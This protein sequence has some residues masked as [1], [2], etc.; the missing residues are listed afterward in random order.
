MQQKYLAELHQTCHKNGM[1]VMYCLCAYCFWHALVI[2]EK[3]WKQIYYTQVTGFW[4][5]FTTDILMVREDLNLLKFASCVMA[6]KCTA[7]LKSSFF[8]VF[9]KQNTADLRCLMFSSYV[10]QEKV[11]CHK[12]LLCAYVYTSYAD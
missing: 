5:F 3:L 12:E 11:N 4:F 1:N 7:K 2:P 6:S 8:S 10:L 9:H